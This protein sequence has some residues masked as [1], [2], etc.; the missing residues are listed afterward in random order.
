M[1][2]ALI[3]TLACV[4]VS[5]EKP[6]PAAPSGGGDGASS[7]TWLSSLDD[8]LAQ[9]KSSGKPILADFGAPW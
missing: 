7:Q 6:K 4:L 1:R 5:C 9:A 8:A 3:A 2:F